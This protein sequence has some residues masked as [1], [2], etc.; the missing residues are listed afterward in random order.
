MTPPVDAWPT[1]ADGNCLECHRDSCDDPSHRAPEPEP[2]SR[3]N[4]KALD[5][6]PPSTVG[7]FVSAL[8]LAR[9]APRECVVEDAVYR[10]GVTILSGE[11][12]SGKTFL[13]SDIGAA[14]S[15]GHRWHGREVIKGSAAIVAFEAD[16]LSLRCQ[17]LEAQ[18]RGIDDLY[19]LRASDPLSPIVQRDGV[20]IPSLGE[21][22]LIDRLARVSERIRHAGRPPIALLGI[23]T[24]RASLTG[25][26]DSS[27]DVSAYLRA[28]RRILA[29]L[30]G[31]GALLNHHTGW[32]DGENQRR[33]ERG[34]SA[35]RGN[36]E[37][38]LY[39]DVI[40]DSD[41]GRVLLELSTLKARDSERRVPLRL[42]RRRVDLLGFDKF[43]N[44]LSS[45]VIESDPRTYKEVLAEKE[46]AEKAAAASKQEALAR[47]V[48]EVIR[49]HAPTSQGAIRG[50]IGGKRDE[51]YGAV[52]KLLRTGLV[53]KVGHRDP[54]TV[55]DAG[56]KALG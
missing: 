54:F 32:Q 38:T 30:P 42:I 5:G 19:F 37:I 26:E 3:T 6:L 46:V 44:P 35:F 24:V 56:T 15:E 49:D 53:L 11:S 21:E 10:D 13:V 33:R 34:S 31:A 43:G 28:I 18:E 40:D 27:A 47:Q 14:V 17:A 51:V 25:S 22:I 41:T 45:C 12:G 23:D 7:D 20:E 55:T 2:S 50:L 9:E 8:E 16:A 48:L 1:D 4:G 39:L 29:T 36:V 52:A